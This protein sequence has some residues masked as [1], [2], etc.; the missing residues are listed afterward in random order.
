MNYGGGWGGVL[1]QGDDIG[2][3]WD[4]TSQGGELKP[5]SLILSASEE[6]GIYVPDRDGDASNMFPFH[7]H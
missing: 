2:M 1:N 3:F 5:S 4:R 7:D 6:R